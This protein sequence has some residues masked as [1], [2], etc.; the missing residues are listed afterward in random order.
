MSDHAVH[1]RS[2]T[3]CSSL[4]ISNRGMVHLLDQCSGSI[5]QTHQKTSYRH[6][7]CSGQLLNPVEFKLQVL[8]QKRTTVCCTCNPMKQTV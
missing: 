2:I 5:R 7:I 1:N 8:D 6:I 3:D 4:K